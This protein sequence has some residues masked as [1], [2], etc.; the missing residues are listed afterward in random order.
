MTPSFPSNH[1]L[2]ATRGGT[3][4]H[5]LEPAL[6]R[7][8]PEAEIVI[9]VTP[10][11]LAKQG[12]SVDDVLEPLLRRGFH[13]HHLTNDYAPDSYPA[14]LRRS[15]GPMRWDRPITEMRNLILS[16]TDAPDLSAALPEQSS[17]SRTCWRMHRI[18]GFTRGK[19]MQ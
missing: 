2:Y 14:A 7:L 15:A 1:G 9:E 4:I 17:G 11:S 8:R 10:R 12:R 5:G 13:L 6:D 16:R 19:P 18:S 3:V